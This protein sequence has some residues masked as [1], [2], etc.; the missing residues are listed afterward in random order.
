MTKGERIAVVLFCIATP[1]V[2]LLASYLALVFPADLVL[3]LFWKKT[4]QEDL[5]RAPYDYGQFA[6]LPA[7]EGVPELTGIE[8]YENADSLEYLTFRTDSIIP[9][10]AYRLKSSSDATD[11]SYRRGRHEVSS[12]VRQWSFYGERPGAKRFLFNRYYLVKLPDGAYV[13][14]FLDDGCY[15]VYRSLGSV[16][17][18]I[19]RVD[20]IGSDEAR[21][22]A[23]YIEAYGLD[24]D[25]ILR[26]FCEERYERYK[27]LNYI[28][29]AAVW[30]LVLA[31]YALL[32]LMIKGILRMHRRKM[33]EYSEKTM[34]ND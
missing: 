21:L 3:D 22:L 9:L 24:G 5:E 6:G 29:L 17:L 14:C 15:L 31:V 28:V 10:S 19:G 34:Q 1:L 12:G 25:R 13:P 27:T 26:M 4:S 18:P 11:T 16:Q 8:Q 7:G 33:S 23:P 30:A 20:Y 32:V 2:S